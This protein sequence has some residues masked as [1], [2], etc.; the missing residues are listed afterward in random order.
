MPDDIEV[1]L[2]TCDLIKVDVGEQI[3]SPSRAGPA[4]TSPSG[5]GQT[6]AGGSPRKVGVQQACSA[7][8]RLASIKRRERSKRERVAAACGEIPMA[9]VTGDLA[10]AGARNISQ[11][12]LKVG[13][14]DSLDQARLSSSCLSFC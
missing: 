2:A 4:S 8:D 13:K 12:C 3:S 1:E 5:P 10:C 6:P 11:P 7:S 14:T 9:A